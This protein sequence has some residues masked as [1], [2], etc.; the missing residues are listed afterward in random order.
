M[1]TAVALVD[2]KSTAV[3]T[4]SQDQIELIKDTIARD[5]GLT[6]DEFRLFIYTAQRMG[7]DPLARQ[8]YAV[9][10]KGRMVI[11]TG[12]D[13]YRATA[14]RTEKYAGNDDAQYD[15][16]V[17]EDWGQR[18]GK[19]TVT[20]CK[21]V[22]GERCSFAA[23]ARWDEYYPDGKEGFNW[24]KMPFLMLAKCAEAL[25]LRKAFPAQLSGVYT[26]EEM[27][28]AGHADP[29]AKPTYTDGDGVVT[30]TISRNT[31]VD[32][33]KFAGKAIK[34]L[35]QKYLKWA[36]DGERNFGPE[37]EAWQEAFRIELDERSQK[38][39]ATDDGDAT[40]PDDDES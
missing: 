21:I 3:Q 8:I 11:Q 15:G 34:D 10:R 33:G 22:G 30:D 14:D 19:A 32:W 17:A 13:G 29:P 36:T 28:Q 38:E 23:S 20:V 4:F 2:E 39:D 16:V 5:Q 1:T 24:R 35:P 9:K 31:A 25:A 18:P 37:T 12:I 27:Q 6:N 40:E 7:L 26:D